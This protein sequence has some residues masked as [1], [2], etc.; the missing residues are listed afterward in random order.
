MP[1][2]KVIAFDVFGTLVKLDGVPREEVKA[3]ADHI[4]K[5]EWSPLTLPESWTRLPA[6]DDS[7]PVLKFLSKWFTVVT[8]TN[9]PVSMMVPLLKNAAID[10]DMV[11]PLELRQV[12]KTDPRAYMLVCDLFR[13]EPKNVLMVTAN[14]KF[15]DIEASRSLGMSAALVRG[16]E[17]PTLWYLTRS[18][19]ILESANA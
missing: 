11:V 12:Y 16:E 19:L 17:F 9:G 10:V 13:V 7:R 18:E 5:P 4:R 8:L 2:I 15:G 6:F 3:Y 14:E 1:E